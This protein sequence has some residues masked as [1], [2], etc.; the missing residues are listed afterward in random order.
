MFMKNYLSIN[1]QRQDEN[2][3]CIQSYVYMHNQQRT[4]Q[5]MRKTYSLNIYNQKWKKQNIR[6]Q[7]IGMSTLEI[8]KNEDM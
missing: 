6:E 8:Q 5:V 4:L 7:K 3:L 1:P 2:N